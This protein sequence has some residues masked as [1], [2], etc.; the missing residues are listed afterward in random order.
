[1]ELEAALQ[2]MKSS[3]LKIKKTFNFSVLRRGPFFIRLAGPCR[4]QHNRAPIRR[5]LPFNCLTV[6]MKKMV[7][8]IALPSCIL[9]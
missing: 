2:Q 7:A 1:M 5:Q 9:A 4:E 3:R 6:Y 8:M